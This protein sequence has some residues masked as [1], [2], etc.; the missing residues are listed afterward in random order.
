M[1]G[2]VLLDSMI[3]SNYVDS[4]HRQNGGGVCLQGSALAARSIQEY[5]YSGQRVPFEH[6]V[7]IVDLLLDRT[8]LICHA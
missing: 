1:D 8:I 4:A 6:I 2:G 7:E 5:S 3:V